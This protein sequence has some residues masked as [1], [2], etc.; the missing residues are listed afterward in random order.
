MTITTHLNKIESLF[1]LSATLSGACISA[2]AQS[3]SQ[4]QLYGL[5]DISVGSTQLAGA[6]KMTGVFNGS[7]TTS[8]WGIRTR[9]DLGNGWSAVSQ[10]ESFIQVDTGA[11]GRT[12]SDPFW[13]RTAMVGLDSPWGL[14]QIGRPV[15]PG[16]LLA[17]T[18]NPFGSGTNLSPYMMHTYIASV[19]QPMTTN[20][21]ASD[22][23]WANS[24]SFTSRP[25]NGW[26]LT[27]QTA[28][29][30]RSATG[31]R[32][33]VA[34]NYANGPLSGG[35]VVENMSGMSLAWGA[36]V[37]SLA[38]TAR[39]LITAQSVQNIQA[40]VS[41]DFGI[42]K[43]FAQDLIT[44]IDTT[45]GTKAQ[46]NT[47]Q[48]GSSIPV[49]AGRILFSAAHTTET[50]TAKADLSRTTVSAAY[51]YW[52]SKRTDVYA[53]VLWDRVSGI[54]TGNSV[55]LGLRHTF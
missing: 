36:P 15:T 3:Q 45:S 9:E 29:A 46:L 53:G 55:L 6:T 44:H 35:L 30:E 41:Y 47:S 5:L 14:L 13:A 52:F 17:I 1:I 16:F 51:D 11:A 38:T 42:V 27:A 37:A 21:G 48:L 4:V 33:T 39:P 10:L 12:S 20:E 24:V 26:R 43:L 49:G 28:F 8:F 2:H 40:G 31:N 23:A 32:S 25:V 22:S 50:Q 19:T 18:M 54:D 34:V 7:M